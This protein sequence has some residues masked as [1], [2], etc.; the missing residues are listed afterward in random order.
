MTYHEFVGRV[1]EKMNI[2]QEVATFA[3]T[4]EFDLFSLQPMRTHEDF[5]NMVDFIDRFA[6]AYILTS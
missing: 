2:E 6:H 3:Y 4:L 1:C 5:T